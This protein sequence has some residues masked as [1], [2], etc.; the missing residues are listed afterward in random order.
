MLSDYL[1]EETM[2]FARNIDHWQNAIEIVTEPLLLNNAI[3]RSYVDAILESI[4]DGGTYIDLGFGIALA[5]ARPESGVLQ[6][7][8][9]AL[10]V[11]PPVLLNDDEKHPITLFF[12]LAAADNSSH[13]Q[14]MADLGRLLTNPSA[15]DALLAATNSAEALAVLSNGVQ[16]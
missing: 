15:R 6:T 3:E 16:E 4:S 9:S 11:D 5:H 14:T 1:N 13:L 12:C 2:R 7:G 10:W 8:L